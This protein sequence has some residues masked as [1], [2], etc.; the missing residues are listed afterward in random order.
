MGPWS[1]HLQLTPGDRRGLPVSG[2]RAHSIVIQPKQPITPH[3]IFLDYKTT[4]GMTSDPEIYPRPDGQV[5]VCGMSDDELLPSNPAEVHPGEGKCEALLE[6]AKTVSRSLDV[7]QPLVQQACYL[8]VSKDGRPIIGRVP[9]GD[10]NGSKVY[11]AT[12][13]SCWGILNSPATGLAVAELIL[14]GASTS[15]NISSFDPAR[16]FQ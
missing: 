8:P 10:H 14:K 5:Y 11:V 1:G 6:V 2:S 9:I 3:A 16:F 12:G 7:P 13:H 15:L 4:S